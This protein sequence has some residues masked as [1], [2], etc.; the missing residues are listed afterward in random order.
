MAKNEHQRLKLLYLHK[1]LMEQ[2]DQFHPLTVAQLI[3]ALAKEGIQAERKSI[4]QD[5]IALQAYGLDLISRTGRS[6]G[7]FVG[8]RD[9]QL[10]ELKLLV[11]AV[12]SSRF[13][14]EKKSVSLIKKLET[15]SSK[16]DAH[17]LN[18]QIFVSGRVKT[19]NESIYYNVDELHAAITN[20][21]TIKFRYFDY[22]VDKKRHFRREGR[23]YIVCP[24]GLIYNDGNYYLVGYD[25]EMN[26]MRH[27]RVDKMAELGFLGYPFQGESHYPEFNLA[28]YAQRHFGMFSGEPCTI[29]LRCEN[30]LSGVIIDRF[31]RDIML[32]PQED[33]TFTVQLPVVLSPQFFGWLFG[34]GSGMKLT[35][36]ESA[37]RRYREHL[38][39]VMTQ[40]E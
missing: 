3:E 28:L 34:L 33:D 18:R 9:F 7:W 17:Q 4:Y 38:R 19:M 25:T 29:T 1:I 20:R 39:Q 26:T 12:Q 36:P 10:A 24:F 37:V 23:R 21:H 35:A 6:P 5:L 40:Y 14:T 30:A 8:E 11:D 31:G 22:G 27:Y 32:I 13:L 15:L 16:H 2:T